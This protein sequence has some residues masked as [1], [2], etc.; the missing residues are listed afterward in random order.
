[1]VL[2]MFRSWNDSFSRQSVRVC[3]VNFNF[4]GNAFIGVSLENIRG[5]FHA[6]Y[7]DQFM[8]GVEA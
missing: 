7:A 5:L 6:V 1:M 8:A 2:R 3:N 4:Q